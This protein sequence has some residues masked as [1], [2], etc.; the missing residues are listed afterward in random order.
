[1]APLRTLHVDTERTWRGGEQQALYLA[2]GLTERGHV[3]QVVGQ[4]GAEFPRRARAAGLVA[5]EAALRG[6]VNPLA[7]LRLARIV[8]A[9]GFDVVHAHTAHAH[10][11][12]AAAARLAGRVPC[13]V[14]RR[15]DFPLRTKPLGLHRLKYGSLVARY[16]AISSAVRDV[17]VA[18]GVPRERVALVPSGVDPSRFPLADPSVVEREFGIGADVP[19][20]VAVGHFAGH[21]GFETLIRAAPAVRAAL[22]DARFVLVG[23]GELRPALEALAAT[24]VPG[25]FLFPGYRDDPLNF[26]ARADAVAAPSL[27]EGLN[28]SILDAL[29]MARPLVASRTGGIPEAVHDER[30]GLLVPPGDAPALAAAL[31][32][33]LEDRDLAR[34]LGEGGRELVLARFT[35]D[36]MVD[37]T[38]AVYQQ[39]LAA[40][41]GAAK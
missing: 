25:A 5:H 15:V 14:S 13:V 29:G 16:V 30:T 9:G 20:V 11:L 21:K 7:I 28:T 38:L 34:R 40:S 35:V 32:R 36:A 6:E 1:M 3:A 39:V 8:S 22:P 27:L 24:L 2:R 23:D 41:A 19:L 12:A 17:L 4:R 33:L 18:G 10:A 31:L 37:G 26:L